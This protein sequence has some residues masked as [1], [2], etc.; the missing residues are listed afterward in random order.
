MPAGPR[1][2]GCRSRARRPNQAGELKLVVLSS[3][4]LLKQMGLY[5]LPFIWVTCTANL[6][7]HGMVTTLAFVPHA[8]QRRVAGVDKVDNAHIGFVNV[9]S[10]Q[11]DCI[12]L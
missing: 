4:C 2:G 10:V 8:Q 9:I 1:L 12:L 11:A 3:S 6:V 5:C 7:A